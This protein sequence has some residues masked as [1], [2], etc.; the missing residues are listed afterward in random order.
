MGVE[1]CDNVLMLLGVSENLT[2]KQRDVVTPLVI[3]GFNGNRLLKQ[4]DYCTLDLCKEAGTSCN[5][6]Q[7]VINPWFIIGGVATG[8]CTKSEFIM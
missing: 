6:G 8:V 3:Q 2:R 4:F 7:T 1:H 5:G